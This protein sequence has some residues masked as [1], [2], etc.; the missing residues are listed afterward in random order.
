[1]HQR[2]TVGIRNTLTQMIMKLYKIFWYS[3]KTGIK[4]KFIALTAHIGN[5]KKKTGKK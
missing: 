2:K 4:R 1:M 3:S 5:F